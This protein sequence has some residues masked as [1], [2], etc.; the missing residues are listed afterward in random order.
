MKDPEFRKEYKEVR[1]ELNLSLVLQCRHYLE[2]AIM[3]TEDS[4]IRVRLDK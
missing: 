2:G 1:A 3:S 4:F